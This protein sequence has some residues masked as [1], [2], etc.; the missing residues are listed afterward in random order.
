MSLRDP[1]KAQ[2]ITVIF[3]HA[4]DT[5]RSVRGHRGRTL[6]QSSAQVDAGGSPSRSLMPKYHQLRLEEDPPLSVLDDVTSP[7][8]EL[9]YPKVTI[10]ALVRILKDTSLNAHHSTVAQAKRL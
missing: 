4:R 10:S 6:P 1:A 8:Q 5:G 3:G 2:E 7:S 9:Y